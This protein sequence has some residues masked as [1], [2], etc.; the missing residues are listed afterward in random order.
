M[1]NNGFIKSLSWSYSIYACVCL[2][3]NDFSVLTNVFRGH[4]V[5]MHT[6]VYI[7]MVSMC[8][9]WF[10]TN[11]YLEQTVYMHAFIYIQ[12]LLYKLK[13]VYIQNTAL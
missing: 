4:T 6:F 8:K 3:T 9:Q 13:K 10:Y 7:Q 11:H 5:Y 1:L 12:L 2:H